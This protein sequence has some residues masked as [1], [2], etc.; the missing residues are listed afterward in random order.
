[1]K[2]EA[3]G[4]RRMVVRDLPRHVQCE[5]PTAENIT[6]VVGTKCTSFEIHVCVSCEN[7]NKSCGKSRGSKIICEKSQ[8]DI[9]GYI[10]LVLGQFI[11]SHVIFSCAALPQPLDDLPKMHPEQ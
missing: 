10:Q 2:L 3:D 5:T 7:S 8:I 4:V 6:R 9:A 11:L 1:M